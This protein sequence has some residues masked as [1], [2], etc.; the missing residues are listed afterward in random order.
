MG[1]EG[2]RLAGKEKAPLEIEESIA[3]CTRVIAEAT[4]KTSGVHTR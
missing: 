2:A 1:N 4:A 3:G